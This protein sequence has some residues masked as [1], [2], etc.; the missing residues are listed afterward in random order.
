[1]E[2]IAIALKTKTIIK[3]AQMGTSNKDHSLSAKERK[4]AP[5]KT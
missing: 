5:T 3:F 4:L 2:S 1:M